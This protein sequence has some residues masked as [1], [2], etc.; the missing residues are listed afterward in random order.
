[1]LDVNQIDISQ[2][3]N[4]VDDS[5]SPL[6]RYE[7]DDVF[8]IDPDMYD[9]YEIGGAFSSQVGAVSGSIEQIIDKMSNF[10]GKLGQV[11]SVDIDDLQQL[12]AEFKEIDEMGKA[13]SQEDISTSEQKRLLELVSK[14]KTERDRIKEMIEKDR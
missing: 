6:K 1:M 4:V 2:Y 7:M 3:Q 11:N 5:S 10:A 9:T 8:D 13:F 12:E 14:I